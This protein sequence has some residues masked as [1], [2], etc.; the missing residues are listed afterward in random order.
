MSRKARKKKESLQQGEE[1]TRHHVREKRKF[2]CSDPLD[3]RAQEILKELS[4]FTKYEF[5]DIAN[6]AM[7]VIRDLVSVLRS[8]GRLPDS[9]PRD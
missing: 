9:S 7:N 1:K 2:I 3:L 8:G 5:S 4:E 6:D